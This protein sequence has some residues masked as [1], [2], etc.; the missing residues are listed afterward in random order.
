MADILSPCPR[1]QDVIRRSYL[2]IP[3]RCHHFFN[4][5]RA[6]DISSSD[7]LGKFQISQVFDVLYRHL[8]GFEGPVSEAF[9][10]HKTFLTEQVRRSEQFFRM[11]IDRDH[12]LPK[13][14][15]HLNIAIAWIIFSK[16]GTGEN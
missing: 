15:R 13:I 12:N 7:G 3:S 4:F 10:R 8:I 5:I 6:E 2:Y 16:N 1:Q 11:G 9:N 14:Q